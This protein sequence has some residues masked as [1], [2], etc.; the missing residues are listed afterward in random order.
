MHRDVDP[1]GRFAERGGRL[2]RELLEQ[3]L[4]E[5]LLLQVGGDLDERHGWAGWAGLG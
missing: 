1:L 3:R 5:S 4:R 2:R